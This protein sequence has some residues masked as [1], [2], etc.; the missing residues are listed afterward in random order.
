MTA[1]AAALIADV[2]AAHRHRGFRVI[3]NGPLE[4][5]VATYAVLCRCG[6]DFHAATSWQAAAAH[7]AHSAAAVVAALGGLTREWAVTM[8]TVGYVGT[9]SSDKARVELELA[10]IRSNNTRWE[11]DHN[12]APD[13]A[14]N[15]SLVERWVSGWTPEE[16]AP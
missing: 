2:L 5:D 15:P 11:R 10:V 6:Q 7:E 12:A 13:W 1:D 9:A 4:D 14:S 3:D 16:P 8:G